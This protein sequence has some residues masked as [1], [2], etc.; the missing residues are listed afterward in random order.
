MD[1]LKIFLSITL[2][3]CSVSVCPSAQSIPALTTTALEELDSIKSTS[4]TR[5][6]LFTSRPIQELVELERSEM[7]S[8]KTSRFIILFGMLFISDHN[9]KS[10]L[11]DVDLAAWHIHLTNV[12]PKHWS[13]SETSPLKMLNQ[14]AASF[15]QVSSGAMPPTHAKTSIWLTS[16]WMDGGKTWTGPSFPSMLMVKLKMCTQTLA[17]VSK[18]RESS[19]WLLLTMLMSFWT[20]CCSFTISMKLISSPGP[21][22][23]ASSC[24]LFLWQSSQFFHPKIFLWGHTNRKNI[25]KR[26]WK[27]KERRNLQSNTWERKEER[28]TGI[29]LCM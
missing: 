16:K 21:P 9:S 23:A 8:L 10:S 1:A 25:S 2:M 11:M 14:L 19:S 20:K 4:S 24:G 15:H 22:S 26:W 29:C 27:E 3:W 12:T 17:S 13:T 5:W 6:R 7:S 28:C 18:T